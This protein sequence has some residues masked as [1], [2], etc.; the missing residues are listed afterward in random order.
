MVVLGGGC[1]GVRS[2]L[3]RQKLVSISP[4]LA[5][6]GTQNFSHQLHLP[7]L[8]CSLP[9]RT[10]GSGIGTRVPH[11]FRW[12]R[13]PA[14][15]RLSPRLSLALSPCASG[16]PRSQVSEVLR[17]KDKLK[18]RLSNGGGG[19]CRYTIP[20]LSRYQERRGLIRTPQFESALESG[21]H[22]SRFARS[23]HQS[24]EW[25]FGCSGPLPFSPK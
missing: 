21:E 12:A 25:S 8:G 18:L 1:G 11:S 4:A 20:A 7:R 2:C 14:N 22:H 16:S 15:L 19:G 9:T 10:P 3:A 5:E 13:A 24:F 17:P 6:R 23:G